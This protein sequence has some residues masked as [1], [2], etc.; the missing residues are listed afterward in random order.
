MTRVSIY[1]FFRLVIC[2]FLLFIIP[3]FSIFRQFFSVFFF[4][5]FS[6][7]K[8]GEAHKNRNTLFAERINGV[9]GG[10]DFV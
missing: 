8:G 9:G 4:F 1:I 7:A 10:L 3:F 6:R 5:V 2:F